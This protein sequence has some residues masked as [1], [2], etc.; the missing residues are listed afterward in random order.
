M[1]INTEESVYAGE[2]LISE[3][4]DGELSRDSV[5]IA[6]GAGVL[7][8]GAVLGKVTETGKYVAFDS[9]ATNGAEKA[10]G[11]LYDSVDATNAD[12]N[13]VAITRVAEVK[14][15]LLSFASTQDAEAK[16][17]AIADLKELFVIAR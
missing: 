16:T 13:A 1:T 8:A 5:V 10:A 4:D 17:S 15:D 2:F 9:A 11:V 12:V 7:K 6:S 14:A 3:A